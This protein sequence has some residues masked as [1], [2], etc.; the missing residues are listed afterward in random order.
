[1]LY[2]WFEIG[3]ESNVKQKPRIS[4]EM[5]LFIREITDCASQPNALQEFMLKLFIKRVVGKKLTK[6]HNAAPFRNLP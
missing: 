4:C 3:T 2:D 6:V 1:M 5:I